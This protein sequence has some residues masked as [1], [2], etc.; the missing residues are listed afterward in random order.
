ML[1]PL[2][3]L[4]AAA[5]LLFAA[6]LVWAVRVWPHRAGRARWEVAARVVLA[7]AA[8]AI[9]V[10]PVGA[11]RVDL[12]VQTTTDLVLVVDRTTS[13][14]AQDYAGHQP[15]MTGVAGDLTELVDQ[16][17]GAQVAVVVFDNDAR[18]AVPFTTDVTTVSTFLSAVGWRPALKATGSD[19][20]VAADLTEQVLRKAAKDRPDHRRYLVYVGDGEQ[21]ASSPPASFMGLADLVS[22]SLVLG[23]GTSKG[24]PMTQSEQEDEPIRID[25]EVQL[26]RIDEGA[27]RS[28][29]DQLGGE[30]QH[31]T[32]AGPLPELVPP[33]ASTRASELRPGKEIY[34]MIA[35]AAGAVL[36]VLLWSSVMALRAAREEVS[37]V[38]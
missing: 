37:G 30:Y 36:F 13:M 19:I 6:T 24:G 26:S 32:K 17:A 23:Y 1:Q 11:V 4:L 12:P 21:T 38:S 31:R 20:G 2:W 18:L 3:P 28:I 8:V 22:G 15:R 27:L 29:A 9:G 5:L 33:G 35:L 14:G 16:L 34:W 25:D 10:H 7:V